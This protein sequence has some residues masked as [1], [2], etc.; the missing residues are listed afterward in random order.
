MLGTK[1]VISSHNPDMVSAIESVADKEGILPTVN[2]YLS[3]P[4]TEND[5]KYVFTGLGQSCEKIFDS[6]NMAID[7][8]NRYKEE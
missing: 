4:D 3:E 5:G 7:R 2:F 8:I 6:F 1:V